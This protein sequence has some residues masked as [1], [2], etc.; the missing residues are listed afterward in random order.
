MKI[1]LLRGPYL[2]PNGVVPWE[3]F[4]NSTEHTVIGFESNPSRFNT[5]DL[6]FP[7]RQLDWPDGS[8][9]ALGNQHVISKALRKFHLPSGYLRGVRKLVDEFDIIHSSEN[10]NIFSYQAARATRNTDTRFV[11]AQGENIPYP[12]FQRNPLLWRMKKYVNDCADGMTATTPKGKRALI[13]EGVSPSKVTVIPNSV[14]TEMFRPS[15]PNPQSQSGLS[16]PPG[17]MTI[18]FVHGLSEQKGIPYL[19]E[20]Y[21]Q[22]RNAHT[23]IGLLLLGENLLGDKHKK[24]IE[25]IHSDPGISWQKHVPY[26]RMPD[27][28]NM[29]DIFVLPS[30]TMVNN[31]EQFGM[32]A[33]EAMSCEL[34]TIVSDVGGLPY[35]AE[36]NETSIVVEERDSKSLCSA[37]VRLMESAKLR[38]RFGQS[39][40]ERANTKF[41]KETIARQL[42]E[43]YREISK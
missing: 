23:N 38:E 37:I 35:V 9:D 16:K 14:N 1:A 24:Y 32:A 18:L 17:E 40:R 27:I 20:A 4:H 30:V 43:F 21:K 31:Q 41:N 11:F 8:L 28:Y 36:S 22:V 34:P 15:K 13:H 12:I 6:D 3:E 26:Q 7:V 29:C 42:D 19:L 39:G 2:R 10:F 33:L 5:S 25:Y